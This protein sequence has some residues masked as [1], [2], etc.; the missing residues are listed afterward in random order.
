MEVVN[1]TPI[2][3]D[4]LHSQRDLSTKEAIELSKAFI[5]IESKWSPQKVGPPI[6]I[7]VIQN[8]GG[9]SLIIY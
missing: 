3:L 2:P 5:Q 6:R 7:V 1:N 8:N 4:K 9:G